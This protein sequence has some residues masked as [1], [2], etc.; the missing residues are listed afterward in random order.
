MRSLST[1]TDTQVQAIATALASSTDGTSPPSPTPASLYATYCSG[2]H[3]PLASHNIRG[4]TS[5]RIQS[6]ISSVDSMKSLA[7]LTSAEIQNIASVLGESGQDTTPTQPPPTQP[8][9]GDGSSLYIT[10]CSGCHGGLT[11]NDIRRRTSSAIQNA[12]T[13]VGSMRSLT[14]LTPTEIQTIASALA[15]SE[16]GETE[17]SFNNI[18]LARPLLLTFAVSVT[19]IAAF[20]FHLKR[21]PFKLRKFEAQKTG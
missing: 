13:N 15:T 6:A 2:C 11:S 20:A 12:I 21:K 3:G 1:L 4:G 19:T 18:S 10:Y 5:Q 14:T 9:P 7:S 17:D 8:S 16:R